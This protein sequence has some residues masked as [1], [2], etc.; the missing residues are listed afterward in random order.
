MRSKKG[1]GA[2]EQIAQDAPEFCEV[3]IICEGK[4]LSEME[5]PSPSPSPSPSPRA[6]HPTPRFA[7]NQQQTTNDS[8]ACGCFKI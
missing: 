6:T 8:F 7:Q 2:A 3:K 1:N 4:E 5:F